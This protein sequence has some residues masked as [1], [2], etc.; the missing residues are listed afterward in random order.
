MFRQSKSSLNL[1]ATALFYTIKGFISQEFEEAGKG[2]LEV[3]KTHPDNRLFL[4]LGVHMLVKA[5][6]SEVALK[7]I[8]TLD[9]HNQGLPMY[10]IEYL[11]GEIL[12]QRG[13]YAQAIQAYQKFYSNYKSLSFKKDTYYKIFLC[14]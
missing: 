4:F 14:Q 6:Q 3:I 8:V 5:S 9:K 10:S 1:E 13:D 11:R 12:L 7:L 2:F